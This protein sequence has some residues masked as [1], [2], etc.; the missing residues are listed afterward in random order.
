LADG[1]RTSG[2]SGTRQ[3]FLHRQEGQGEA[4]DVGADILTGGGGVAADS[5]EDDDEV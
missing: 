4:G 5:G 2:N 3:A 1:A